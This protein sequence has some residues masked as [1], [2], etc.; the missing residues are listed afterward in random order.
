MKLEEVEEKLGAIY[1]MAAS[2][3]GSVRALLSGEVSGVKLTDT[4]KKDIKKALKASVN[5][6]IETATKIKESL[7]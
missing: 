6:I 4:Q 5:S 1:N 2:A 7:S 3:Q